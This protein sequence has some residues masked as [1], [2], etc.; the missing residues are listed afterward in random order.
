[1]DENCWSPEHQVAWQGTPIVSKLP[2]VCEDQYH[3]NLEQARATN[4]ILTAPVQS[5]T[6]YNR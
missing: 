4:V 6:T 3:H 1:M 5:A 2:L